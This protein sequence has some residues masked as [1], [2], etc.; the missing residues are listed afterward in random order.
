MN[1]R[2]MTSLLLAASLAG[3]LGMSACAPADSPDKPE[4]SHST[5]V[6]ESNHLLQLNDSLKAELGE[7]Y[8]DAW[9]EDNQ[10]NV[11]VTTEKAAATVKAAGAIPHIVTIDAAQLEAALQAIAA[12]QSTLPAGQGT[13]IHK[14]IPDGRTGSVTIFVAPDQLDAVSAAA[15]ADKPAGEVPL[16]IKESAGLATP[17]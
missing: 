15:A 14:I 2:K 7:A 10:L 16:I 1:S 17:L 12:W 3:G 9:I 4:S 5:V 8:S 13:A 11:A 6:T